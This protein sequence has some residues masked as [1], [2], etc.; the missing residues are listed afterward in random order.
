M[1]EKFS[2]LN[3]RIGFDSTG[4]MN[5]LSIDASSSL[6]IPTLFVVDRDGHIAFIGHPIEIDDSCRKLSTALG[7]AAMK[8]KPRMRN[9][10][11]KTNA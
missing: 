4:E 11:R 5:T 6:G 10:L 1:T 8:L 2:N 3:Y 7:A 9:G